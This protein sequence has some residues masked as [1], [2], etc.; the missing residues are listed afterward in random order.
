L[1]HGT[2]PLEKGDTV[3][4]AFAELLVVLGIPAI[5]VYYGIRYHRL[6]QLVDG[7]KDPDH[8]LWL[9]RSER[10]KLASDEYHQRVFEQA[11][12]FI[13]KGTTPHEK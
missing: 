8:L 2:P 11:T 12:A 10:R 4:R 6:K 5:A 13:Q 3:I 9:S 7:F 1:T